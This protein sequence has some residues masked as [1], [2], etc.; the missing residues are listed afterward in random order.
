MPWATVKPLVT[1]HLTPDAKSSKPGHE[2]GKK[3]AWLGGEGGRTRSGVL[4]TCAPIA[5]LLDVYAGGERDRSGMDESMIEGSGCSHSALG[6]H[7]AEYA[8]PS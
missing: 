4:Q 8:M 1:A 2:A 7:N 5:T 6:D 3:R